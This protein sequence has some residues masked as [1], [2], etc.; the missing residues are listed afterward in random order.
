MEVIDTQE[1]TSPILH[2]HRETPATIKS[3]L[4]NTTWARLGH[5]MGHVFQSEGKWIYPEKGESV[6]K[7][8]NSSFHWVKQSRVMGSPFY[9][10]GCKGSFTQD[11]EIPFETWKLL[12]ENPQ[13]TVIVLWGADQATIL[14][15]SE[16][17]DKVEA[18][19]LQLFP[20]MYR[21]RVTESVL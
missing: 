4:P 7:L 6:H 12:Q 21:L 14:T 17:L 3:L 13:H 20:T 11:I 15:G 18:G 9:Y 5:I 19:D 10:W 16:I 1:K 8:H 2:H